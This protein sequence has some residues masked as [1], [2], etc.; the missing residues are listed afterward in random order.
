[1]LVGHLVGDFLLQTA[2]MTENK[3]G[4]WLPLLVHCFVYTAAVALLALPAGGIPIT[5]IAFIFLGHIIIDRTRFV[6]LWA[7]YISRSPDNTWLKM[8]QDQTWH[9]IIL[10]VATLL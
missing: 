4:E 6:D 3:E 5:A 10:A 2:W 7:K 8:V 1:M 9:I